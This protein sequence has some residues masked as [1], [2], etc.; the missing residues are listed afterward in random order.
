M[1]KE[2]FVKAAVLSNGSGCRAAALLHWG[3]TSAPKWIWG[4]HG[5]LS[6]TTHAL[7]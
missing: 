1:K 5:S 6:S 4:Y 7:L 3:P 2:I